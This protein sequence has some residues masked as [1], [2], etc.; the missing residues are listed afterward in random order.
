MELHFLVLLPFVTVV[1]V[2]FVILSDTISVKPT[3]YLML[4]QVCFLLSVVIGVGVTV[5]VDQTVNSWPRMA[6]G[7]AAAA[8]NQHPRCWGK[9]LR[10]SIS[11]SCNHSMA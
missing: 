8:L 4:L 6:S 1:S 10:I 7:A 9:R 5:L 2:A 3:G 11:N